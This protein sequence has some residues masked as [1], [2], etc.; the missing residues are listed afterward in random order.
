MSVRMTACSMR[1]TLNNWLVLVLV[2]ATGAPARAQQGVFD[3]ST[4][5]EVDAEQL[6]VDP[7]IAKSY[8]KFNAKILAIGGDEIIIR[9]NDR[10]PLKL[11]EKLA[12][13]GKI[14]EFK[15][16]DNIRVFGYLTTVQRRQVF[17]VK[18]IQKRDDDVKL[19]RQQIDTLTKAG[20]MQG[21]YK[22][23][24]EIESEGQ[25]SK[26]MTTFQPIA[27]EAYRAGMALKEKDAK[28][29]DAAVWIALAG[30][31]LR[32]LGDRQAALDRLRKA[33]KPGDAPQS[34]DVVKMLQDLRA[35]LYGG[36][37]VLF[38]E[39]KRREGFVERE[40]KWVLKERA[41]FDDIVE[42]QRVNKIRPRKQFL[43]EYFAEVARSGSVE[44]GMT[45]Q[46]VAQAIG[47]PDEVD[48]ARSSNDVYDMWVYE[49]R[50]SLYFENNELFKRPDVPR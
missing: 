16:N 8:L 20:D 34:A 17:L 28:P 23:G 42:Q 32:L 36:E 7:A 29:D 27:R 31:Y 2:L 25:A 44:L 43:P 37:N 11:D 45:K 9:K 14:G 38:E 24:G 47:F 26:K 40:G 18:D 46:E 21:L 39:M 15:D 12:A 35:V 48:R 49:G 30:D 19:F 10:I 1:S 5:R 22:L 50:G 33:V 6:G 3:E 4:C 41:E 13:G